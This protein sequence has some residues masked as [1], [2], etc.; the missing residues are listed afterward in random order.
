MIIYDLS[1][2]DKNLREDIEQSAQFSSLFSRKPD[3]LLSVGVDA[4]TLKSLG[5]SVLT[6]IL[7][8]APYSISG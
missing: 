3:Q 8:L 5:V 4:K 2:L 6:G 7:Y 1:K